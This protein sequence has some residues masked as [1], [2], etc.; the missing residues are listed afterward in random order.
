MFWSWKTQKENL[1]T[2]F[3]F[4]FEA[5]H[6]SFMWFQFASTQQHERCVNKVPD[7]CIQTYAKNYSRFDSKSAFDL[8]LLWYFTIYKYNKISNKNRKRINNIWLD[9][10]LVYCGCLMFSY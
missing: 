9:L 7:N 2:S 6:L 3:Y 10:S 8:W 4:N 1:C 5:L